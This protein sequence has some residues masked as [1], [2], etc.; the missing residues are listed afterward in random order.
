MKLNN[1][2]P[3]I[4]LYSNL[5]EEFALLLEEELIAKFG[6]KDLR[7]GPLLNLTDGGEFNGNRSKE[8]KQRM[9]KVKKGS[10]PWNLGIPH[11]AE[12]RDKIR[13]SNTGNIQSQETKQKRSKSLS[14][15]PKS[16]EHNKNVSIAKTGKKRSLFSEEWKKKMSETHKLRWAK[17]KETKDNNGT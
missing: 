4:G 1:T 17:I 16:L 13:K 6:R 9:S 3:I 15:K 2:A 11:S 14:G 12:T 10:V 7:S 8:Y 5:D